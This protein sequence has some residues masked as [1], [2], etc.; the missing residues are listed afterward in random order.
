M[1]FSR[2]VGVG[3]GGGGGTSTQFLLSPAYVITWFRPNWNCHY[4][5]GFFFSSLPICSVKLWWKWWEFDMWKWNK[6]KKISQEIRETQGENER[7]RKMVMVLW[8]C[9][10][11]GMFYYLMLVWLSTPVTPATALILVKDIVPPLPP[12]HSS[13]FEAIAAIKS[14]GGQGLLVLYLHVLW[15]FF[16]SF[17]KPGQHLPP[18]LKWIN[19]MYKSGRFSDL[20]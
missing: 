13:F 4:S 12:S 17:R 7:V 3:W 9:D 11:C 15:I 2:G 5:G 1:L 6:L 8:R 20:D 16:L 10:K 14:T 19:T 18:L